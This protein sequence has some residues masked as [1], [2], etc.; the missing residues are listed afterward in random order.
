MASSAFV[1]ALQPISSL[2]C[3]PD[4][5]TSTSRHCGVP[6]RASST[7]GHWQVT[8]GCDGCIVHRNAGGSNQNRA[9]STRARIRPSIFQCEEQFSHLAWL[10]MALDPRPAA[11]KDSGTKHA[12]KD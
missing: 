10:I 2:T 4:L 6:K 9:T 12:R 1:V 7:S 11:S 3:L 5:G 8:G